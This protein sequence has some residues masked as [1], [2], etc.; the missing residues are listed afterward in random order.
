MVMFIHRE[1]MY[2]NDTD[3]NQP[4]EGLVII[5]KNREGATGNVA[6]DFLPE[7]GVWL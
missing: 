7:T 6:Y 1:A 5:A 2:E 3:R 4:H